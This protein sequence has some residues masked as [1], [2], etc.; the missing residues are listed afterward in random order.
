MSANNMT[1]RKGPGMSRYLSLA[2]IGVFLTMA[3]VGVPGAYAEDTPPTLE[4][5]LNMSHVPTYPDAIFATS[6]E[7]GAYVA[8]WFETKDAAEKVM[9]WYEER[10]TGWQHLSF[11][12]RRV[13]YKGPNGLKAMQVFTKP[14]P[15][16]FTEEHGEG[17][18]RETN[19]TIVVQQVDSNVGG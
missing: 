1:Q 11:K 16:L 13:L 15:Y 5:A 9:Q 10:L 14:Y 19:I 7:R 2:V 6:D 3:M 17:S 18:T 12:G 4:K 8:I